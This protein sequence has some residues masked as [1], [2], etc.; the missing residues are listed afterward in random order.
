[1]RSSSVDIYYFSGTGNT[2]LAMKEFKQ[3]FEKQRQGANVKFFRIEKSKPEE[4]NLSHTIG[5]AVPAAYFFVYPFVWE[6]IKKLPNTNG[7][8]VF[9]IVTMGGFSGGIL[10]IF[11]KELLKKSYDCLGALELKMY[12]NITTNQKRE[13]E[14][15]LTS[16]ELLNKISIFIHLL[17]TNKAVWKTNYLIGICF[18]LMNI[19][20][21]PVNFF[22]KKYP[23]RVNN[24]KCIQCG[25]CYKLCPTDN[26][27]MYEFPRFESNCQYCM[28]CFSYCPVNAIEFENLK[29]DQYSSVPVEEVLLEK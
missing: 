19:L 2:F 16:A 15:P 26:I 29:I 22:Q 5:I 11:K 10:S 6:F 28:R 18:Y 21:K 3:E 12:S 13:K 14:K 20:F 4:I 23:V 27:R 1:M 8:Q 25:I 7:T 17:L 24:N 9:L